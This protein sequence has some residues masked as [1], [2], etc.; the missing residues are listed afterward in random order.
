MS[1]AAAIILR[2]LYTLWRHSRATRILLVLV[3]AAAL[4]GPPCS[5][6]A[7]LSAAQRAALT[8]TASPHVSTPGPLPTHTASPTATHPP[9]ATPT[10]TATH[11][12]TA[13]PAPSPTGTPT[14]T[15]TP[16]PRTPATVSRV[17][18]ADTIE[19]QIE[20]R[21]FR[22]R[23]LGMD[24]PEPAEW[25]GPEAAEVNRQLLAG[26]TV[27]LERDATDVDP[28]GRLL[29]YVWAGDL[30]VNAEL[31][32]LGYAWASV[33]PPD[34]RYEERLLQLERE[35]Q[36]AGRGRWGAQPTSTVVSQG[37]DREGC[38]PSYPDVC[39]PPPPPDL[40]CPDIPYRRFRVLPPDPHHFD[41]DGDGIGCES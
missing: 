1:D 39:I 37:A 35:A 12:P 21:A 14:P 25:L 31:V 41:R 15:L 7:I 4:L 36:A 5:L 27:L 6:C 28:Y 10:P 11:Q 2:A 13:T 32:R 34:V 33:T 9:T 20:G 30:L 26:G 29:R 16:D 24:A 18:D 40:D 19:V 8:A 22:V 17:I 38:D 3:G 23:Y